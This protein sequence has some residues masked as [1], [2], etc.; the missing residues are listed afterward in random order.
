MTS[1]RLTIDYIIIDHIIRYQKKVYPKDSFDRFGD[2][3]NELILSYLGFEDK[4]RLECLSK[5]WKRCVFQKEFVIEIDFD[6][7]NAMNF[8]TNKFSE[9]TFNFFNYNYLTEDK[10]KPKK[11]IKR[12]DNT[13]LEIL[14][15]KCPNITTVRLY[16][17]V[18]S[19]VLSLEYLNDTI[20]PK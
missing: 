7:N 8:I 13:S 2:D 15:K 16:S 14:L 4:I 12:I 20:F 10:Q 18:K 11:Q 1:I 17:R 19:E 3:L 6:C 5:Q 9:M